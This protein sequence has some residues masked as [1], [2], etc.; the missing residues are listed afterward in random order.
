MPPI[1]P[2]LMSEPLTISRPVP[3]SRRMPA[4]L[5]LRVPVLVSVPPVTDTVPPVADRVL[6]VSVPP[7]TFTAPP[8]TERLPERETVASAVTL[9]DPELVKLLADSSVPLTVLKV[10]RLTIE[11]PRVPG[12]PGE[13]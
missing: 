10:P 11:T 6:V 8:V 9:K 3:L 2:L 12:L 13:L 5:T 1:E 7:V 4:L